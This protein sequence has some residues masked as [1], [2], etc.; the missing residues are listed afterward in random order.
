[1]KQRKL[2]N[3]LSQWWKYGILLIMLLATLLPFLTVVSVS[4]SEQEMIEEFG[5]HLIPMKISFEGYRYVFSSMKQIINSYLVTIFITV[6]GTV[7]SL[8]IVSAIAYSLSRRDFMYR[9]LVSTI[10]FIP[11]IFSGGVVPSY[12]LITRYLNMADTIWVLF[13]PGLVG[14]WNIFLLRTFFSTLPMALIEKAKIEGANE[15]QI[16]FK[17]VLPLSKT[18]LATVALFTSLSYWNEW[19]NS[20]LYINN[21]RFVTLQLLLYR[22]MENMQFLKNNVSSTSIKTAMRMPVEPAKTAM[23]IVAAGPMLVVFPFFQKYFVKGITIG[24]VKG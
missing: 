6:V 14:V 12:I 3:W 1:M 5:Y 22:I 11:M 8:M 9:R 19:F 4:F 24:A 23:V 17:I 7:L 21:D 13:V 20:L 15:L 10:V 2:K 18:G 16:Y